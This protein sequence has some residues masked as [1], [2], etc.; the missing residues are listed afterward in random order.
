ML[1]RW[2]P[3][4]ILQGIAA[5]NNLAETAFLVPNSDGYHLRWF[6]PA[7]EVD[8]CGHATLAPA[9]LL[10][11]ELGHKGDAV[12]FDS[13]S[14]PL[15]ARRRGEF[16]ELDF[17]SR[18]PAACPAPDELVRGLG[19]KPREILKSRDFL[20]V[21]DSEEE[22]MALSPNFDLLSRVDSLGVIATARGTKSDFVSRFFA[23]KAGIPEDPATG[24]SHCTLI[25]Y[26]SNKLGKSEM[27][28]RQLSK[29]GGEF[30]C[31]NLG[32]RVGIGG[33]AV[34]YGRGHIEVSEAAG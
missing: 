30:Q 13:K 27:S 17:P 32:D 6:T 24:S 21:F 9:H 1:K 23:P 15:N 11:T 33:R 29:R 31:R 22:V 7:L 25:P 28:A 10:F 34:I 26:W 19:A 5:E 8:L 16:V 3:D 4:A 12:R 2:L 20:A 18:P 14:G